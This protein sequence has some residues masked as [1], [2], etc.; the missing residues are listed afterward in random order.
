[1][2]SEQQ[3]RDIAA[4]C[5][6]VM[7]SEGRGVLVPGNFVLTA[8]HAISFNTEGAMALGDYFIED[9]QTMS[10]LTKAAPWV[11]EPVLDIAALGPLDAQTFSRD[12]ETF[13]DWCERTP[14]VPI[15]LNDFPL[16][17]PFPIYIYTHKGT[18]LEGVAQQVT[19]EAP[20]LSIELAENIES[21]TSGSPIVIATG[22]LVG[23]VSTSSEASGGAQ[24]CDA[25]AP[26]PHL[27][28][29]VW[30]MRRIKA[31]AAG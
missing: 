6:T 30:V 31:A 20:T 2:L 18:W 26:R 24:G 5:V 11:V 14:P 1:M 10:G 15:C 9:L 17:V 4:A 3:Q 8:A 7:R 28:L 21:G 13:M 12:E 25:Q 16:F 19:P 23:V 27:A 29:P 22:E